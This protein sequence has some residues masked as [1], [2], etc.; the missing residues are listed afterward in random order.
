MKRSER[1]KR[2]RKTYPSEGRVARNTKERNKA[3]PSDQC[4]E[5]E[6]NNRMGKTRSL[7][8]N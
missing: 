1:Q 7:Q 4:K 2:K 3:S 5:I 6:E 8:E